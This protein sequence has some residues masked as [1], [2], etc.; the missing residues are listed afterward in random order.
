MRPGTL[1]KKIAPAHL[2]LL[3]L[4]RPV[5]RVPCMK[6]IPPAML[7]R[8]LNLLQCDACDGIV[9]IIVGLGKV[10]GCDDGGS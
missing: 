3:L 6:A 2:G 1:E 8:L 4:P 10:E 7:D 9:D 5:V